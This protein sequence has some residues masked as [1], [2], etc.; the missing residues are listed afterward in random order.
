MKIELPVKPLSNNK[1]WQGRRFKTDDYLLY[2]QEVYFSIRGGLRLEGNVEVWYRFYIKNDKLTDCDNLI[3]P[4]QDIL[5][6][7]GVIED[8]RKIIAFH[9]EKFHSDVH[10]IE[11]EILPYVR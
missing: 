3:K 6:K 8:D 5:V 11:I 7:R 9:A 10:K 2:E 4:L 1:M